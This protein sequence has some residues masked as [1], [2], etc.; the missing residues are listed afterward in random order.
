MASE[1]VYDAI[2]VGSG[3]AG[4]IAAYVL[5]TKGLNVLCLEAGRMLDPAQDFHPHKFPFEWQYRGNGKP[6]QY[7]KVPLGMEWKIKEWTDHLYT[8]PEEDPYAV[9]PGS[10]FT[11]TRLR[12]VGGRTNLWGREVLRYGPLDFKA[13]SLQDGWGEDW[14]ISYEDVE[15]YYDRVDRLIGVAGQDDQE[16]L[17]SPRGKNLLPPFRLRCGEM[18]LKKGAE[19]LGMKVVPKTL[20]VLSQP[21]DGRPACHYCGAC[22]HG[23]D[24][25]ARYCSAEVLIPKLTELHNFTLRTNAAVHTVLMDGKTGRARGVTYIDTQNKQEYEAY[26]KVVVLAA[27]MVESIR[28]LLNSKNREFPTGLA[29]S[30]GMLGHYV[31]DNVSNPV[32]RGFFPQL[33]GRPTTNDDGPGES[34][35]LIPRYNFGDKGKKKFLRGFQIDPHGGCGEGPGPG[36]SLPGFGSSYK[37]RIKEL[38]PA[39]MSLTGQGEGLAFYSN[40]VEIDPAGLTDR[41]GIPQVRFHTNAEYDHAFAMLDEIYGQCEELLRAAGA[42]ILP[43]KKVTPY[44]IGAI[45]HEA[46]GCRMGDD[47]H[48]SVLDKW[49]RCHDVKNLLVVDASCYVTHPEKSITGTIMALSYRACDHLAEEFRLGNV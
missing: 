28:I 6:G 13:K 47:P 36:A 10:K 35:I 41:L 37:K 39:S 4:G 15:P 40:Y 46:G 23:C 27:S 20:A 25:R 32:V 3:A 21:Y 1:S 11:W 49:N 42:E 30:S 16:V 26:S 31:M 5:A 43:Y 48:T 17:N 22:S 34:S 38:Y 2:V 29:N 14:P 7:G 24:V 44:P 12:A 18:L 19:K 9:A 33:A 45:T 8:I